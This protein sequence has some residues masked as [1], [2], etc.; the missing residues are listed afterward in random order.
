LAEAG[1]RSAGPAFPAED[2]V[3]HWF[4][5]HAAI[6]VV[7]LS[8]RHESALAFLRALRAAGADAADSGALKAGTMRKAMS[9][10]EARGATV[11]YRVVLAVEPV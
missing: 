5:P 8:E 9:A 6:E 1:A 10:F 11:T 7:T 4:G 3:R 2:E